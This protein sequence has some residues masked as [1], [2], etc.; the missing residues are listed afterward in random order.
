[1]KRLLIALACLAFCVSGSVCV[2]AQNADEPASRDDIILYLRTM[3]SHDMFR[4]IME[5]QSQNMQQ[6]FRDQML[7]E[8]GTIPPEFDAHFKKAMDDM[9]KGMPIDEITQAMIPAYQKHFTKGDI[10]AM[11]AFYSSP[12][13]QK[14]LQELPVVVQEGSQAAMP[15]MS[16]YISEWKDRMQQDLKEM[17]D[18]TPNNPGIKKTTPVVPKP[19]TPNSTPN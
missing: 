12:V 9:I 3:R 10:E 7:K 19:A 1:M 8:K 5:V 2:L 13:G 4:R 14:V 15:I 18:D 11:N 6:L 17:G 16:K